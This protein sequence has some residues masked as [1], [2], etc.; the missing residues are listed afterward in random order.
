MAI[1]REKLLD[2]WDNIVDVLHFGKWWQ[3]LIFIGIP[4]FAI[5]AVFWFRPFPD[6]INKKLVYLDECSSSLYAEGAASVLDEYYEYID[7]DG[8]A[9]TWMRSTWKDK[10]KE[11]FADYKK[12]GW[13][14]K[15]ET[16]HESFY[17]TGPSSLA[18]TV[19]IHRKKF[20]RGKVIKE[21]RYRVIYTWVKNEHGWYVK[22]AQAQPRVRDDESA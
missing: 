1:D 11:M 4:L 6:E 15:Q 22:R 20:S 16:S 9:E 2:T 17:W 12:K 7:L 8:N 14:A 5:F 21:T 13:S 19:I 18:Q 10:L 3:R